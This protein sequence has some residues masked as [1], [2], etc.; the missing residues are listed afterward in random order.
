V[1][2][3]LVVTVAAPALAPVTWKVSFANPPGLPGPGVGVRIAQL[4][5]S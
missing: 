2:V 3:M 1:L 4:A 5:T